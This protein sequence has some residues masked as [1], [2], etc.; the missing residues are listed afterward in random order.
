MTK[1]FLAKGQ[2]GHVYTYKSTIDG[3]EVC[4]K[5]LNPNTEAE[6]V[7]EHEA[8]FLRIANQHGIGPKLLAEEEDKVI[9]EFV[10]GERILDFFERSPKTGIVKV[11]KD[12]LDQA[13]KLDQAGINKYELTNPHKHI[14]VSYEKPI[15]IDFERCKETKKPK[16][17]TQF[18]QFITSGRVQ[19]ILKDK[20][21]NLDT[22]ELRD[23]AKK[24]K[25]KYDKKFFDEIKKD[26]K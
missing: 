23:L 24:Y 14:I 13:R 26:I 5:E 20:K 1:Q 10:Q 22:E 2:R 7:I 12:S 9:M 21:F 8:K 18:V 4:V 25:D 11:I 17:V 16:N 19:R 6:H 15:M 3:K